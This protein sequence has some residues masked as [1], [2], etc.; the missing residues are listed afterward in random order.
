M[1]ISTPLRGPNKIHRVRQVQLPMPLPCY[2]RLAKPELSETGPGVLVH[3]LLWNAHS[4]ARMQ[5]RW[6]STERRTDCGR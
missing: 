2:I 4:E 1:D 5:R 3:W 6:M